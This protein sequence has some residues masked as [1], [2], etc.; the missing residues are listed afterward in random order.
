MLFMGYNGVLDAR[1]MPYMTQCGTFVYILK[2]LQSV[3]LN[4]KLKMRGITSFAGS[5]MSGLTVIVSVELHLVKCKSMGQL[6]VAFK[7]KQIYGV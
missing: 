7:T 1:N 4:P 3:D 6:G 2:Y 5:K